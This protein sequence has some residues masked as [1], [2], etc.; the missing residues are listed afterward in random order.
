MTWQIGKS[1]L[2]L[3]RLVHY[4]RFS[5]WREGWKRKSK[6]PKAGI[7]NEHKKMGNARGLLYEKK[8]RDKV[9][10]ENRD[11]RLS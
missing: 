8:K 11:M 10:L 4:H 3:H 5:S 7:E 9:R 2:K 6:G 1:A